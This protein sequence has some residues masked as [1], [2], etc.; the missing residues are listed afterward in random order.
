V[1]VRLKATVMLLLVVMVYAA[2]GLKVL[3]A[4]KSMGSESAEA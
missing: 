4:V 2:T 3:L 1:R